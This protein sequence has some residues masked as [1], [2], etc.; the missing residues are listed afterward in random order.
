[1][2]SKAYE[3]GYNSSIAEYKNPYPEDSGE[4]DDYERG[5]VQRLKRSPNIGGTEFSLF[6]YDEEFEDNSKEEIARS[7]REIL[8]PK[9]KSYKDIKGK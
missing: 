6:S 1:M 3:E 5:W 7:V 9:Y 4:F 2:K 8:S